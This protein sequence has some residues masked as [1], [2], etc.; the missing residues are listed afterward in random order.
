MRGSCRR[1]PCECIESLI[2]QDVDVVGTLAS[3]DFSPPCLWR[4][5]ASTGSLLRDIEAPAE[6][7]AGVA[8]A[9]AC[10]VV[11]KNVVVERAQLT[12][13]Y[14]ARG[15]CFYLTA[16]A[17][18]RALPRPPRPPLCAAADHPRIRAGCIERRHGI[19]ITG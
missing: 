14:V 9:A 5:C 18:P 7:L 17:P 10:A 8:P 11:R 13:L 12:E 1:T 19:L 2:Q 3:E 16:R 15:I 6:M 4:V